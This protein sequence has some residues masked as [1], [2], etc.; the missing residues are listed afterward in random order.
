VVRWRQHVRLPELL[1]LVG[2]DRLG[3]RPELLR[4][5]RCQLAAADGVSRAVFHLVVDLAMELVPTRSQQHGQGL[6]APDILQP[7]GS[8]G[9]P[10]VRWRQHVRL[11]ELLQLVGQQCLGRRPELLRLRRCQFGS[12]C[13]PVFRSGCVGHPGSKGFWR[14][15][16]ACSLSAAVVTSSFEVSCR[17]SCRIVREPAQQSGLPSERASEASSC[18]FLC[19]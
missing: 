17:H 19:S 9:Q 15:T 8:E 1:Q 6:E 16:I 13:L 5:R 7:G 10:V 12:G 14:L 3:R 2:Q 11:P 4:L 18:G